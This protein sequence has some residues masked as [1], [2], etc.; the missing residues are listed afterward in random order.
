MESS[1]PNIN[2][3]LSEIKRLREENS[4]LKNEL[5]ENTV[6]QSMNYMKETYNNLEKEYHDI[7]DEMDMILEKYEKLESSSIYIKKDGKL[8]YTIQTT[9]LQIVIL[10]LER[11]RFVSDSLDNIIND[12]QNLLNEFYSDV[13][14]IKSDIRNIL[15][16]MK[17]CKDILESIPDKLLQVENF[18][19]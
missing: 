1:K 19:H 15:S 9:V 18:T 17:T 13:G 8:I 3:L 2:N 4:M 11:L 5:N 12:K 10:T 14:F 6:I 7:K 16:Y